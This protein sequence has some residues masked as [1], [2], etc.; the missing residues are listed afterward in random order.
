MAN[1]GCS[2]PQALR[3]SSAIGASHP[4]LRAT[5]QNDPDE[6]RRL[7]A[8]GADANESDG[9]LT[10]LLAA[11]GG[12]CTDLVATLLAAGADPNRLAI[13]PVTPGDTVGWSLPLDR[14]VGSRNTDVVT[15]LLEAGADPRIDPE[16]ISTPFG[17][18]AGLGEDGMVQSFLDLGHDPFVLLHGKSVLGDAVLHPSTVTV[19]LADARERGEDPE[20]TALLWATAAAVSGEPGAARSLELLLDSGLDPAQQYPIL[21]YSLLDEQDRLSAI[22]LATLMGADQSVLSLLGAR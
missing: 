3:A 22:E 5:V 4:L 21:P 11:S 19:L 1:D 10:P 6:V 2:Q 16:A 9:Q 13:G 7:L 15:L 12:G 20:P 8:A 18:A 14:A 17:T